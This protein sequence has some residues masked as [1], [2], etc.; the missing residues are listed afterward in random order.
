M[1]F[2]VSTVK[3]TD[4]STEVYFVGIEHWDDFDLLLGLLQQENDCAILSNQEMVYMRKAV[5]SMSGIEFQLMH[6]DMLG[7]YLN[8]NDNNTVTLLEKMANRIIDSV[9]MK[10][11]KM[12]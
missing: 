1:D 3:N 9:T 7:N 4:G 2:R 6:D 11:N 8:T 12:K 5:L 10:L